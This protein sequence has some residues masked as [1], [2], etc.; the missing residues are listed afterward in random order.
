MRFARRRSC[1]ESMR[2][3]AE[4]ARPQVRDARASEPVQ[5]LSAATA[6][7]MP[8]KRVAVFVVHLHADPACV[9]GRGCGAS[10]SGILRGGVVCRTI[11]PIHGRGRAHSGCCDGRCLAVAVGPCVWLVARLCMLVVDEE[12]IVRAAVVGCLLCPTCLRRGLD[13]ALCWYRTQALHGDVCLWR[14][15]MNWSSLASQREDMFFL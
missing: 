14:C 11:R 8:T 5:L 7:V 3:P 10:P 2:S 13:S 15:R 6:E 1:A 12:V 9:F 4:W